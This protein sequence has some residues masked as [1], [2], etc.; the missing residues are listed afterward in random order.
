[1]PSMNIDMRFSYLILQ[2]GNANETQ[3]KYLQLYIIQIFLHCVFRT[4]LLHT[5]T[6]THLVF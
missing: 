3:I 2:N 6:P 5:F 1:M 4:E